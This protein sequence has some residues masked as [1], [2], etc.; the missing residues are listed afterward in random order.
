MTEEPTKISASQVSLILQRAAEIDAR[1]D[2]LTVDELHRIAAEAGIDQQATSRAIR[3][4]LSDEEPGTQVEPAE[5][6]AVPARPPRYPSPGRVLAGGAIGTILGFLTSL[7]NESGDLFAMAWLGFGGSMFYL[8]VR[9]LHSMKRKTQFVFQIEN[10]ALWFGGAVGA[11][12][13]DI[14]WAGDVF[15]I[16]LVAWFL[17]S[18]VGGLLVRLG[19]REE[20]D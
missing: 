13:M 12:A 11:W 1:G 17:T 4:I 19:P 8:L 2:T 6:A 15:G 9:A 3:E 14:L 10:F 18:I 7:A 20:E 5:P 16:A